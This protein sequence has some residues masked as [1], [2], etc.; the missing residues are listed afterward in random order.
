MLDLTL[1][2]GSP[3]PFHYQLQLQLRDAIRRGDLVAGARL[4]PEVDLA[5]QTGVSRYTMRQAIDALVRDGS[6]RRER[7][8]G[9]TVAEPQHAQELG[10]FYSFARDFAALGCRPSSRVLRLRRVQVQADTR[11]AMGFAADER[12]LELVRL[13]LLDDEPVILETSIMP[14]SLLPAVTRADVA[15]GSLYDLLADHAGVTV[16]HADEEVRA[17]VLDAEAAARLAVPAGSAGFCV[18]RRTYAGERAVER[19]TSLIRADRYRFHIR[20]PHPQLAVE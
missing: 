12:A 4:P 8:R 13:R 1:D 6:L 11:D 14:A 20:L 2:R 15:G 3:V 9:T 16:T 10:R 18:E 19:R 5:R 7:G 17:V